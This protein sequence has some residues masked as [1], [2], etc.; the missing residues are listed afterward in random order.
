M[1]IDKLLYRLA[2]LLR[3]ARPSVFHWS[4]HVNVVWRD[5]QLKWYEVPRGGSAMW[6][7]GPIPGST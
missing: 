6:L 2:P 3:T 4:A 5:G 1:T 7:V